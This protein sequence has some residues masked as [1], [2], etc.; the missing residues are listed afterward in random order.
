MKKIVNEEPY[1]KRLRG[2]EAQVLVST[3]LQLP[4]VN[5]EVQFVREL[6]LF[7]K[8]DRK[9]IL[10]TYSSALN[11]TKAPKVLPS[12]DLLYRNQPITIECE[13]GAQ[14]Y[15]TLNSLQVPTAVNGKFYNS[16]EGIKDHQSYVDDGSALSQYLEIKCIAI[17]PGQLD[18]EV[19]TRGFKLMLG[20]DCPYQDVVNLGGAMMRPMHE[21]NLGGDDVIELSDGLPDNSEDLGATPVRLSLNTTP[22]HLIREKSMGVPGSELSNLSSRSRKMTDSRAQ[23]SDDDLL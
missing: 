23:Y 7:N 8:Y 6:S 11:R 22:A 13:P 10:Q 21:F 14:V 20:Q 4:Q 15:Y 2:V 12:N 9:L 17:L 5:N 16:V 1:S 18:S 3:T 19:V